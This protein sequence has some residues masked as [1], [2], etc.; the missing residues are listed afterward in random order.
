MSD[1]QLQNGDFATQHEIHEGFFNMTRRDYVP[2]YYHTDETTNGTTHESAIEDKP[3]EWHA[4]ELLHATLDVDFAKQVLDKA[5]LGLKNNI[6]H[7]HPQIMEMRE[8]D[9][10]KDE[11]IQELEWEVERL[12]REMRGL[13]EEV[14]SLKRDKEGLEKEREGLKEEVRV[15]RE[16]DME[17]FDIDI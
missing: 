4:V 8:V 16:Y 10:R 15:K 3:A 17:D 2:S 12:K 5:V 7:I 14:R 11:Q 13:K 6:S 9:A 1:D